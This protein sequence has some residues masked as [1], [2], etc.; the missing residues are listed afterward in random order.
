M[1]NL[2][3]DEYHCETCNRR[4]E[5]TEEGAVCPECGSKECKKV[6][7]STDHFC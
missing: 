1:D 7:K 6:D 2:F 3:N 5:G 4:F